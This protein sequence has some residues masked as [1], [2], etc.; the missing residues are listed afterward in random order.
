MEI[1]RD[2]D[3]IFQEIM[4]KRPK[5]VGVDG[6]DGVGKTT[7][8]KRFKK[9]GYKSISIDTY[10]KKKS[11]GYFEFIDFNKL[12]KDLEKISTGNF[13][14]E[15]ILLQKVLNKIGLS[16]DHSIYI[17]DNVWIYD[18]LEDNQGKYYGLN[19]NKIIEISENEVNKLNK[20][21][22]PNA[23]PYKMEGFRREIYKYSYEYQPWNKADV[24][25]E[26]P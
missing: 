21:L 15:G 25:L 12:R 1:T 22:S 14:I 23:K 18:W 19:L 24:V 4:D 13:V 16:S 17:S 10:L 5:F 11:G 6:I 26:I 3:K 7:F 2:Q 20:V 9:L 8:A